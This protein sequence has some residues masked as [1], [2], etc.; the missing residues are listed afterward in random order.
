LRNILGDTEVEKPNRT[1][2]VPG[3]EPCINAIEKVKNEIL[4]ICLLWTRVRLSH[5]NLVLIN[6]SS[7]ISR[8][9]HKNCIT[10]SHWRCSKY[11]IAKQ[12]AQ[13]H[14]VFTKK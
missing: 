13:K 3:I 12:A 14:F 4:R 7:K 2:D 5:F 11:P 1:A 6:F 9:P 10:A 8:E